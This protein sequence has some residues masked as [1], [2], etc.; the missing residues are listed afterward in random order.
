MERAGHAHISYGQLCLVLWVV[1]WLIRELARVRCIVRRLRIFFLRVLMLRWTC[2]DVVGQARVY[3][4]LT[5]CFFQVLRFII[6]CIRSVAYIE[7]RN[8]SCR[9]DS[10]A[11]VTMCAGGGEIWGSGVGGCDAGLEVLVCMSL[12]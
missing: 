6:V 9:S 4:V 7:V 11:E 5:K 12:L 1:T 3:L 2:F 8:G 10:L